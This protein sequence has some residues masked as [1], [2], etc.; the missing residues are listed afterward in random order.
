MDTK[1]NDIQDLLRKVAHLAGNEEKEKGI[2]SFI[3]KL[4]DERGFKDLTPEVREELVK[5]M[6]K[7]L[8]DFIAARTIGAFTDEDV[9]KF[10]QL[11]K[12]G[13]SQEEIQKFSATHIPNY[14]DFLTNTLLEFR[15]VYLG[16]IN[17]PYIEKNTDEEKTVVEKSTLPPPAP[18]APLDKSVN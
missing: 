11:L 3:N 2:R 12:E 4:L 16:L 9:L 6:S 15:G 13:K 18:V 7:R 1:S 5:D 10:E 17:S 14:T 8:D